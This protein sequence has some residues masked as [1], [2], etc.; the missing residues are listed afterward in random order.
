M[1]LLIKGSL[2]ILLLSFTNKMVAQSQQRPSQRSFASVLAEIKEKQA[3]AA[4]LRS[5][6]NS[7]QNTGIQPAPVEARN[8]QQSPSNIQPQAV[9]APGT[10]DPARLPSRQQ[11]KMPV[12][13][14][15]EM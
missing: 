6:G 12:R 2:F 9:P 8:I 11:I 4:R 15:G 1:K 5:L 3:E 13:K 10:P 7:K 14:K